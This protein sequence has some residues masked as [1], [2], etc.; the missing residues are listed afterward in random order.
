MTS[1]KNTQKN[2]ATFTFQTATRLDELKLI[3]YATAETHGSQVW[4]YYHNSGPQ[5]EQ[6]GVP[7]RSIVPAKTR[8]ISASEVSDSEASEG[9]RLGRDVK[10]EANVPITTYGSRIEVSLDDETQQPKY[11]LVTRSKCGR[12]YRWDE[13]VISFLF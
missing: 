3:A 2:E 9:S 4:R 13:G 8:G 7:L 1:A 11:K 12:T 10:Q 6:F 5:V